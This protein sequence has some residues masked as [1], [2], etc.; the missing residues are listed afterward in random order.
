MGLSGCATSDIVLENVR[1]NKSEM[2][3]EEG[4][5]FINA[6]KTL[7]TGRIV[8][9]AQGIGIAQ[10]CLD[11]AISYAKERKQFGKPLAKHQ[12]IAFMIADMATKLQAA[13][14]LL[15]SAAVMKD[16]GMD[17]SM[18]CSMAKYFAT[19][20]CNEI[21]ARRCRSMAGMEH[22]GLQDRAHVSG[23]AC[24]DHL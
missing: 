5:G 4:E 9:A 15:Y 2:I 17:A 1:V 12:A 11:E 16:K 18:Y 13:K 8:V 14:E 19:E 20:A 3:G 22:Q 7:D 23:R 24:A 6:M 21:A 10:G